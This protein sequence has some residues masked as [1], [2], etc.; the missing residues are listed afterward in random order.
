MGLSFFKHATPIYQS[1]LKDLRMALRLFIIL[2]PYKN[3]KKPVC[4]VAPLE[5]LIPKSFTVK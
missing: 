4:C 1:S 2:T 5:G 3:K